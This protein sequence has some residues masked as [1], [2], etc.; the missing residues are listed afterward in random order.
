MKEHLA[1]KFQ[2]GDCAEDSQGTAGCGGVWIQD[3]KV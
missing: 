3:M 1:G 2:V